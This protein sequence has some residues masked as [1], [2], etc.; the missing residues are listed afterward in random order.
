M[1][2]MLV[3]FTMDQAVAFFEEVERLGIGNDLQAKNALLLDFIKNGNA[4]RAW[5]TGRS[6]EDIVADLVKNY[7]DVLE[8]GKSNENKPEDNNSN[9]S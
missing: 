8:M 1:K 4:V 3:E 2:H 7:G 9:L 5:T 6:K